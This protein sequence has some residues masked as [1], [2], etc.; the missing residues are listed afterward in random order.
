MSARGSWILKMEPLLFCSIGLEYSSRHHG[1]SHV[2]HLL[3]WPLS[4]SISVSETVIPFLAC[5]QVSSQASVEE[6]ADSDSMANQ[7]FWACPWDFS[8]R[9]R[10]HI[11]EV[12]FLFIFLTNSYYSSIHDW[13]PFSSSK[14]RQFFRYSTDFHGVV[15]SRQW[16]CSSVIG[17]GPGLI[18]SGILCFRVSSWWNRHQHHSD[19]RHRD[20]LD[21][22]V[23]DYSLAS[24]LRHL[25]V[26]CR[27][28]HFSMGSI[29]PA[30]RW[31]SIQL[32]Y[33]LNQWKKDCSPSFKH[34]YFSTQNWTANFPFT[35]CFAAFLHFPD[36]KMGS[37]T[38]LEALSATAADDQRYHFWHLSIWSSR[39][40][41]Q[42]RSF[43]EQYPNVT[44]IAYFPLSMFH[45]LMH[46]NSSA[47]SSPV[48][49]YC[50]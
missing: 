49:I 46:S 7:V 12:D 19:L 11:A 32:S 28:L 15:R 39:R 14:P 34:S 20:S 17:T 13:F 35:P 50:S 22:G 40:T 6:D 38:I 18:S 26:Q 41:H 48:K 1:H 5:R 16:R 27:I 29:G 21:L 25:K 2:D 47:F 4:R 45:T 9:Y 3:V 44:N 8:H 30:L 24:K 37:W 23:W 36:W 31:Y 42:T 43:S 10:C 33:G